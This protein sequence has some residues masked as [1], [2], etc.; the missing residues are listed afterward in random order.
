MR[1]RLENFGR[2]TES[3]GEARDTI[4]RSRNKRTDK[5][6]RRPLQRNALH[7]AS[8]EP[9][10]SSLSLPSQTTDDPPPLPL[11]TIDNG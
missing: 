4:E 8:G 11:K 1:S 3:K 9:E 6:A 10:I 5:S 7:V 2:W